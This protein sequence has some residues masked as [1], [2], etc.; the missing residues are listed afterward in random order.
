MFIKNITSS[1]KSGWCDK[2]RN[3]K[4][5]ETLTIEIIRSSQIK[6]VFLSNAGRPPISQS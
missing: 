3:I 6:A 5:N 2:H 4:E 1:L